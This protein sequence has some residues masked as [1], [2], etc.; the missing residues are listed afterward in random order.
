MCHGDLH[1][2]NILIHFEEKE[3]DFMSPSFSVRVIDYGNG[4]L[5]EEGRKVSEGLT[6]WGPLIPPEVEFNYYTRYD[7]T[8]INAYQFA[9]NAFFVLLLNPFQTI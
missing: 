8:G 2:E 7:P 4:F 3:Q 6:G 1:L 9:R 5:M